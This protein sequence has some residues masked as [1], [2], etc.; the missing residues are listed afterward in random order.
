[1]A[2]S[3]ISLDFWQLHTAASGWPGIVALTVIAVAFLFARRL[4]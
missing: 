4:R 1:M 2:D 3:F